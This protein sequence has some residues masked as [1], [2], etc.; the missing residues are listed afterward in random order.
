L[1]LKTTAPA[2][3]KRPTEE[4]DSRMVLRAVP[5]HLVSKGIGNLATSDP[6]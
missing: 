1:G 6:D 4:A 5:N 2:I 3:K